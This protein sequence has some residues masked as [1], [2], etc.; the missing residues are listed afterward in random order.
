MRR[1]LNGLVAAWYHRTGQ[2]HGVT[3]AALRKEC[4]GP[5]AAAASADQ[6]EKRIDT[7]REWATRG[8]L[9]PVSSTRVRPVD[10]DDVAGDGAGLRP[11][12][13]PGRR[14]NLSP[15]PRPSSGSTRCGTWVARAITVEERTMPSCGEHGVDHALQVGV[16]AGHHAAPHVAGA[17]DR[18][19]LEHLRDARPGA[20]RRR[21]G[22]RPG[23]WRISRV[24]NAV[25]G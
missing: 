24:R 9:Q 6:L 13:E 3:H 23:P 10:A 7:I 4:G 12:V 5:A 1:E 2:P 17:G 20:R 11:G 25:T 19:G 14:L 15:R 16:G 18:A 8:G 22:R 21:R